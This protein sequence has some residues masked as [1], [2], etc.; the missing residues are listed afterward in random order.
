MSGIIILSSLSVLAIAA[1]VT[2]VVLTVRDG[3]RRIPTRSL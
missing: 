2:A 3:Y 1:V